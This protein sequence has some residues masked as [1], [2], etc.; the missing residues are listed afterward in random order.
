MYT[1]RV[2]WRS[3]SRVALDGR[4]RRSDWLR[5][6]P[7]AECVARAVRCVAASQPAYCSYNATRKSAKY[8]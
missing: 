4:A 7:P 2:E 3:A 8:M 6:R 5:L 1:V